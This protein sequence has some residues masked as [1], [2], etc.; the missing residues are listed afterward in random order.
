M[1]HS[2]IHIGDNDLIGNKFNGFNLSKYLTCRGINSY[3]M[4]QN[5][6]STRD[7]EISFLDSPS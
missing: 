4:V 2:C 1:I 3:Y 5:G 7:V 6:S